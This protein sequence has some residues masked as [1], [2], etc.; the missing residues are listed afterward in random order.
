MRLVA[1]DCIGRRTSTADGKHDQWRICVKHAGSDTI[2]QELETPLD[3]QSSCGG[4]LVVESLV[5][6]RTD[7]KF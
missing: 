2:A 7:L 6:L 5:C 3:A 1:K 4:R